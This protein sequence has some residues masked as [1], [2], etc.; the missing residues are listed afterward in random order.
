M[1]K[2]R[3]PL[4]WVGG[5]GQMVSKIVPILE[6][7]PH[8]TYVEPFG[9]GASLLL[10]KDPV[11]ME[12]Y[13]DIDRGLY[14]FFTV[15]SDPKLFHQFYRRVAV[16]PYSRKLY[17]D[18]RVNWS[19]QTDLVKRV[20]MWFVVARQSFGGNFGHS[21]GYSVST[22]TRRMPKTVSAWLSTIEGLPEVHAR[23]QR[24][25]IECS[26]FRSVLKSYDT[27]KT[28]FY[29]DPPYVL[30]TRKGSVYSH[31]LTV[32][33]HESLTESL[34]TLKGA[35]VL[36]AYEHPVYRPLVDAGWVVKRWNTVCSVAAR[37]RL[38][39]IQGRGAAKRKQPRVECLYVHPKVAETAKD[40][41]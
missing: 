19:K 35:A 26:D 20:A 12:V 39:E 28:L 16:L 33:D 29:C 18:C 24:V 6:R 32:S 1:R 14:D 41:L 15:I 23:F 25:Q 21:W 5:K 7:W 30:T 2:L 3:G 31:E 13:N 4:L 36:S 34:L 11:G 22:I 8:Q 40:L 17:C 9:G 10:S 38:T 27:P 37:T